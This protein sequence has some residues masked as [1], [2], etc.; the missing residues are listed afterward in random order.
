ME[1]L[2]LKHIAPYLAYGLKYYPSEK[3]DLFHDCYADNN[4]GTSWNYVNALENNDKFAIKLKNSYLIPNMPF[5]AIEDG[6]LFLGQFTSSLGFDVDDVFLSE[7]MPI[8]RPL[9]D[10]SKMIE[11]NSEMFTP[12][13][14]LY[15]ISNSN[16]K[17]KGLKFEFIDSW[18]AGKIL[19]VFHYNNLDY[20]EFIYADLGFRK[21]THYE[22]GFYRFGIN[23]PHSIKVAS[24]I[25]NQYHLQSLLFEWHFDVFDR[26]DN[27]LSI[28]ITS[29]RKTSSTSKPKLLVNCPKNN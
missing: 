3:S 1:H 22:K 9:S 19:K 2:E 14:Y 21:D 28:G 15:N 10:L 13:I 27:G 24:E 8:L 6:E 23:L 20:T 29:E 16:P 26:S 7:V 18:G 5:V 17:D 25:N 4:L 11:H 12:L